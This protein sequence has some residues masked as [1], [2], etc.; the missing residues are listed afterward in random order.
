[1]TD[2]ER[3]DPEAV[4]TVIHDPVPVQAELQQ[5]STAFRKP[6]IADVQHPTHRTRT[7]PADLH[8]P[9]KPEPPDK[10]SGR[11]GVHRQPAHPRYVLVASDP[12]PG[13]FRRRRRGHGDSNPAEKDH[14]R[15]SLAHRYPI[16]VLRVRY[17][18][19]P[20]Y[21][22][23]CDSLPTRPDA[24]GRGPRHG[25]PDAP[26]ESQLEPQVRPDRFKLTG[27]E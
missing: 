7:D 3:V 8:H 10:R 2:I 22:S 27:H 19:A 23:A 24:S 4:G 15:N 17:A 18:P 9:R 26:G 6:A 16:S 25:R 14:D 20:A 11:D 1:M 5:V 12:R 21:G 13:P